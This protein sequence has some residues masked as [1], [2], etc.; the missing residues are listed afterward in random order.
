MKISRRALILILSV[1][2][3]GLTLAGL[4]GILNLLANRGPLE[5]AG[6]QPPVTI[7]GQVLPTKTPTASTPK[8]S[9]PN[10]VEFPFDIAQISEL[11]SVLPRLDIASQSGLLPHV[12][13]L[14]IN[15]DLGTPYLR[16]SVASLYRNSTWKYDS[17]MPAARYKGEKL[18][19]GIEGYNRKSLNNVAISPLAQF[20][21]AKMPLP[22]GQYVNKLTSGFPV[23]YDANNRVFVSDSGIP[24]DYSFEEIKYVFDDKVLTEARIASEQA[25]LAISPE[26]TQRTLDLAKEISAGI[27]SPYL[28]AKAIEKYLKENY[29]YDFDYKPAPDNVEPNDWFLFDE[30]K[31]LCANFNSAFVVLSRASGVPAR[32]V[33]GYA[34]DPQAESQTV[35]A[36]QAHAWSEIA[37][38]KAGWVTFDATGPNQTALTPTVTDITEVVPVVEKNTAFTVKG[39]VTNASADGGP[40]D[41]ALV[42]L[43]INQTKTVKNGVLIGQVIVSNGL[44][45][46]AAKIPPASAVGNYQLIARSS[47][48]PRF[49]ESTSD[50]VIKVMAQTTLSLASVPK[51]KTGQALTINGQLVESS[52][53]AIAGQTVEITVNNQLLTRVTT[54]SKG[55]FEYK[56][57]F[58]QAG[59]YDIVAN[60]KGADFYYPC[61]QKASFQVLIPTLLSI[62]SPVK[63]KAGQTLKVEGQLITSD[64]QKPVAGQIIELLVDAKPT[65]A[66]AKTDAAGK[67]L[68]EYKIKEVGIHQI[69]AKYNSQ[70]YYWDA[71]ARAAIEVLAAN[72]KTVLGLILMICGAVIASGYAGFRYFR[73]H[74]PQT[75]FWRRK[76]RPAAPQNLEL[77]T[78]T[79]EPPPPARS[80]RT[81]LVIEFPGI[82]KPL[83]DVWGIG[84]DFD[85]NCQLNDLQG[86]ALSG[87]TIEILMGSPITTI[88]TD[89]AGKSNVTLAFS[90][91]GAFDIEAKYTP[92]NQ[93]EPVI[94][95]LRGIRIV[96]YR[97]EIIEEY[98][99]LLGWLEQKEI[100]ISQDNTPRE[101]EKI[102]LNSGLP[103]SP[104]AVETIIDIFEEATYSLHPITR[105]KFVKMHFAQEEIRDYETTP[106]QPPQ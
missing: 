36:D 70:P 95:A 80:E 41:G 48:T 10:S 62:Q 13:L 39:T 79:S 94:Q 77:P 32:M 69:D 4:Q 100:K 93:D 106:E 63:L 57:I 56:T 37:L 30:K 98:K 7:N 28:K 59:Q 85:I 101:A 102:I 61:E 40:V 75:R 105:Q 88:T 27:D 24:S 47:Q 78:Q 14:K 60:F 9:Q 49:A 17:S 86:A 84:D 65:A 18:D 31:G 20:S 73:K 64:D 89:N 35:Y 76:P 11:S 3:I 19:Y 58:K 8:S 67:Y 103:V 22:S 72:N 23:S 6:A 1:V 55:H 74:K 99:H 25:D 29:T 91:K 16:G 2:V 21:V 15:G 34:V 42:E 96:D 54:D 46:I 53:Q 87:K 50:P 26:I 12:P 68:L 90:E 92:P 104:E 38:D 52:K 82:V 33:S 44:F 71:S 81:R 97:E 45:E 83:P 43:F 5:T 66:K 51:I